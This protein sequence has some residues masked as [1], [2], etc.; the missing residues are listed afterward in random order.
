ML[1]AIFWDSVPLSFY[2][3]HLVG[4]FYNSEQLQFL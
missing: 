4:P 2:F 3:I 1:I